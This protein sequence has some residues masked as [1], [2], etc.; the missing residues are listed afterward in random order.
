MIQNQIKKR[1][2]AEEKIKI[3]EHTFMSINDVVNIADMNDNLLFVNPAFCKTYG[4]SEE[5]LLGKNTSIVWSE[6]NPEEMVS[7]ILPATLDG[8][9]TG[10]LYNR[11]KDGTDFP[12]HL[13]TAVIKNDSG[14]PI[15]LVGV[16]Q[17]ITKEKESEIIKNSLYKISEAVNQSADMDSFYKRIHDTVKELMPADNFYISLYDPDTDLISFP[18]FVDET[19][20]H[21]QPKNPE[22]AALNMY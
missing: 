14:V 16:C 9:W 17:D 18:Y 1:Q 2:R 21:P 7:E 12:I 15:A 10:E 6:R 4:Y 13:S 11:R 20:P 22:E 8:G 3:Y 19:D 5:E